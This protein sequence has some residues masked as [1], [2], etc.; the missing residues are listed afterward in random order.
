M[1]RRPDYTAWIVLGTVAGLLLVG[2]FVFPAVQHY[3]AHEDC[4]GHGATNCE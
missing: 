1:A 4:I 3:V 2:F